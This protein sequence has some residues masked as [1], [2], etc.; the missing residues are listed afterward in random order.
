[1]AMSMTGAVMRADGEA[2]QNF[3]GFEAD[4]IAQ[5]RVFEDDRGGVIKEQNDDPMRPMQTENGLAKAWLG[6]AVSRNWRS[7]GDPDVRPLLGRASPSTRTRPSPP[8]T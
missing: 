8:V 7:N 2:G 5:R 4:R 6:L 3:V 1:M